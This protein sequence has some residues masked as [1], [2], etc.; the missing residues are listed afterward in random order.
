MHEARWAIPRDW[1]PSPPSAI[2]TITTI[3]TSRHHGI[4]E[5]LCLTVPGNGQ[6]AFYALSISFATA[7]PRCTDHTYSYFMGK[8]TGARGSPAMPKDAQLV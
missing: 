4:M 6:K 5:A 3:T 8:E 1:H 2:T 7:A